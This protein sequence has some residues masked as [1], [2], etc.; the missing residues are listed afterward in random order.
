MANGNQGGMA[1]NNW[2]DEEGIEHRISKLHQHMQDIEKKAYN[3]KKKQDDAYEANEKL[4][5]L[6]DMKCHSALVAMQEMNEN[7]KSD[8]SHDACMEIR[9]RQD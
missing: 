6:K 7:S 3:L 9:L 2:E 4:K 1:A 5:K 8:L